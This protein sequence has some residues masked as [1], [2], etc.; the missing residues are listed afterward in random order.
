[1]SILRYIST[2]ALNCTAPFGS[3]GIA[4]E[5]K[6]V[7]YHVDIPIAK[8]EGRYTKFPLFEMAKDDAVKIF[9]PHVCAASVMAEQKKC[10]TIV[11][12]QWDISV[13]HNTNARRGFSCQPPYRR[14]DTRTPHT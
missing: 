2:S 8:A 4:S 3:R 7:F 6:Q 5:M 11:E 10:E 12:P 1:M 13:P 14:N 9:K